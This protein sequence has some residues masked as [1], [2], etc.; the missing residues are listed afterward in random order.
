M[1]LL[2]LAKEFFDDS[3][4]FREPPSVEDVLDYE[5]VKRREREEGCHRLA[6]SVERI[7][8]HTLNV[9]VSLILRERHLVARVYLPLRERVVRCLDVRLPS[10]RHLVRIAGEAVLSA[11]G[12]EFRDGV[13]MARSPDSLIALEAV[14]RI[15]C[16]T[17]FEVAAVSSA[18]RIARTARMAR[19]ELR[20][21]VRRARSP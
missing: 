9:S 20:E 6:E 12:G 15:R 18:A 10:S 1:V 11:H 7:R 8:C 21:A 16:P 13:V 19:G 14:H 17:G 5:Q 2:A 4:N 3:S